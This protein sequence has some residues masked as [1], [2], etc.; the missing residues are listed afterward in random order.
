VPD[1]GWTDPAPHRAIGIRVAP[2]VKLHVLDFGGTGTPLVFL[3][4]I[5]N[6]AHVFDD[7]TQ[8]FTRDH[9]VIAITRRGFG[10]SSHP[11]GPYDQPTLAA[12]IRTVLDSLNIGHAILA[13]HSIGGYE[14]T[15]FAAKYP[16]RVAGLIYLDA[17]ADPVA[18][19][20]IRKAFAA[21]LAALRE[22][23]QP[24]P[25]R[26]IMPQDADSASP[27]AAWEYR[28]RVGLIDNTESAVRAAYFYEGFNPYLANNNP[29]PAKMIAAINAGERT[30]F[31]KVRAPAIFIFAQRDSVSDQASDVRQ[32][33]GADAGRQAAVQKA[34]DI[35]AAIT[36]AQHQYVTRELKGS[37]IVNVRGARHLI[38]L[39]HPDQ[40][41]KAMRSF[42]GT[43]SQSDDKG[44]F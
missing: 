18:A 13:G 39:T 3:S 27:R 40:V 41:E 8:R 38:F 1:D 15:H 10:E 29:V 43:L 21:S 6:N 31:A 25:A 30:P 44:G 24:P 14:L 33:I 5:G 7:F 2:N 26:Q 37:R 16:D 35:Q 17:G 28:Q 11:D 19:D 22:I 42:I 9:R 36:R 4:G 34:L 20:S 32:W 12:D 23:P